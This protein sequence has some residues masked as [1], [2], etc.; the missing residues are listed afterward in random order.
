MAS[1]YYALAHSIWRGQYV[2]R[3]LCRP[4]GLPSWV[5]TPARQLLIC[6]ESGVI[7]LRSKEHLHKVFSWAPCIPDINVGSILAERLSHHAHCIVG[8]A[9][10]CYVADWISG[11][12]YNIS[13]GCLPCVWRL[14]PVQQ[15]VIRPD[16]DTLQIWKASI[17]NCQYRD[18]LTFIREYLLEQV[19]LNF[20]GLEHVLTFTEDHQWRSDIQ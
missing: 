13:L 19:F 12:I 14:E 16:T 6:W 1:T 4:F 18:S 7:L 11:T 5:S 8:S 3:K 10:V 17:S 2:M 15:P 9:S 20:T